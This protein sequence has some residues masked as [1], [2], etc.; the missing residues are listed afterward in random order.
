FT[1]VPSAIYWRAGRSILAK[2]FHL[3]PLF[4]DLAGAPQTAADDAGTVDGPLLRP[5]GVKR[6]QIYLVQDSDEIALIELSRRQ[7]DCM[8]G[9]QTRWLALQLA[10]RAL[11]HAEAGQ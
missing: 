3:H 7:H 8:G 1:T 5:A 2:Y 11:V 10:N 4:V 6:D 9:L